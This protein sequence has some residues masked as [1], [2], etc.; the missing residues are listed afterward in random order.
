VLRGLAAIAFGALCW[1]LPGIGLL[2]LVYM[3]G[4]W[5]L[6]DGISALAAAIRSE[7]TERPWWVLA[8]QGIAGI[9]AGLGA[10][11]IPGITAYA[12]LMLIA[13]WAIIAGS[14]QIGTA[15]RL[16]KE[17]RG[18]WLLALGGVVSVFFGALLIVFPGP[19]ALA[20]VIWIGAY[21]V[22]FG[23]LLVVLGLRMRNRVGRGTQ[24][25]QQ[26]PIGGEYASS[27]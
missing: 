18:E 21:A 8:L 7:A 9:A 3:F 15:I 13:T 27:H 24:T 19:G 22:L 23:A 26:Q 2:S 11:L 20:L 5:A 17:I 12:L 6:V 14:L 4:I 10:F 16:R 1:I 25:R